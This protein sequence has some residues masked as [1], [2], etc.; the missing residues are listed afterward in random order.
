MVPVLL[1]LPPSSSSGGVKKQPP[2]VV[3]ICQSGKTE[4]LHQRAK[5]VAALL[6]GGVAVCLL[7]VRGTGE[8][9]VLGKARGRNSLAT[10]LSSTQLMLG[11]TMVGAQLRDLRA[12][13]A[14][15]RGRADV[16]GKRM[17]VWGDS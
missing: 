12:V 4:L 16:D 6:E 5:E 15:L 1:L 7:D 3:A 10:T 8:S 9:A 13:L 14:W 17:A 2:V 11:E